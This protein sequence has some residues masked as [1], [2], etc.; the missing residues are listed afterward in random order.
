MEVRHRRANLHEQRFGLGDMRLVLIVHRVAQV[1]QGGRDHFGRRIEETDTAG[2][3][4]F[5][6]FRFEQQ[7][8]GIGRCIGA[9]HFLDL[10]RVETDADR[11]P[12]VRESVGVIRVTG[13]GVFQQH[14]IEILPVRQLRLVQLLIDAGLDLLGQET[15]GRHDDVVAGLAR[16]QACFKGFVAVKDIVG[17][18]DAGLV[19]ELLDGVRGNVIRPVVDAQNLVIGL[20]ARGDRA[21]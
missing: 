3:E 4:F 13:R 14:R 2:F 7:V 5:R 21:Q 11:A 19:F 9:E 10:G 16:Q 20:G 8:P 1:V 17:H 15:V 6:V 12:H 18:A